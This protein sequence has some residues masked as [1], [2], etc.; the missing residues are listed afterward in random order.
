MIMIRTAAE[1]V[2]VSELDST[3]VQSHS[4]VHRVPRVRF[5]PSGHARF[6]AKICVSVAVVS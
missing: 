3:D 6:L 4:E 5:C 2:S 1:Q